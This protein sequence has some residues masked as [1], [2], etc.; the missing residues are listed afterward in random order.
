MKTKALKGR[1]KE[2]KE[3][4]PRMSLVFQMSLFLK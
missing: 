4:R 3:S 1:A 2:E